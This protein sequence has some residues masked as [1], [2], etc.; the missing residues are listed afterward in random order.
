MIERDLL[1]EWAEIYSYRYGTSREFLLEQIEKG[2]DVILSIDVQGAMKIDRVLFDP[3]LIFL[4]PPSL[5]EL[6]KRLL[7]RGSENETL[8]DIRL[9]RALEELRYWKQYNFV[10]VNDYLDDAARQVEAIILSQRRRTDKVK[11]DVVKI[12]SLFGIHNAEEERT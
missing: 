2:T 11:D 12:L 3:V 4:L 5:D 1:C 10:V 8:I 6:K 9:N 7:K